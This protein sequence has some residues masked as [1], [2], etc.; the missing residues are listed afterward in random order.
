MRKGQDQP[1]LILQHTDFDLLTDHGEQSSSSTDITSSEAFDSRLQNSSKIPVY[2]IAW[3]VMTAAVADE[4]NESRGES[5]L[6]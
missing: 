4:F 5:C 3:Q 2:R 6:S 1:K